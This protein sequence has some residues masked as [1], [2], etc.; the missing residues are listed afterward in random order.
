M[1]TRPRRFS[2]TA[3]V[4]QTHHR[5]LMT[6]RDG[7]PHPVGIRRA[8]VP[9]LEHAAGARLLVILVHLRMSRHAARAG[10]RRWIG[11]PTRPQ[12]Q[13]MVVVTHHCPS[14]AHVA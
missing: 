11:T 14:Q 10:C 4:E 12:H 1:R 5:Y 3:A 9:Y 8:V 13:H 7:P 2:G 6:G